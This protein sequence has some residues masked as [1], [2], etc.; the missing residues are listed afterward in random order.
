MSK[1]ETATNQ[2]TPKQKGLRGRGAT[3]PTPSSLSIDPSQ[4]S[5]ADVAGHDHLASSRLS[6][7]RSIDLIEPDPGAN[8][9]QANG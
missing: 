5:S 7:D 6:S 3:H 2:R 1:I 8:K 4:P 9:N